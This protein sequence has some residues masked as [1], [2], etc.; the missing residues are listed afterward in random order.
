MG[1]SARFGF[2][3]KKIKAILLCAAKRKI[4]VRGLSLKAVTAR[5]RLRGREEERIPLCLA[6]FGLFR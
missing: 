4:V 2:W 1:L 5:A 6:Q 3:E